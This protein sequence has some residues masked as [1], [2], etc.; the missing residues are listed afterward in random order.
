MASLS[1]PASRSEWYLAK[2]SCSH[3][4]HTQV[5]SSKRPTAACRSISRCSDHTAIL[6][7]ARDG[8]QLRGTTSDNRLHAPDF[9]VVQLHFDAVRVC[10]TFGEDAGHDALRQCAGALVLLLH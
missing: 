3:S 7:G 8:F 6:P 9:A 5:R 2:S 4:A 10:G 1:K